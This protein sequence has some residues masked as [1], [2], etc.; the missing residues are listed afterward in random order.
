MGGCYA[1]QPMRARSLLATALGLL[2]LSFV[3]ATVPEAASQGRSAAPPDILLITID[4]LRADALGFAGNAKAAT[5]TLDRLARAGTWFPSAHAHNVIT[6]PSHANL[7]TG[8]Y[9]YQHGVRENSGFRLREGFPT[10]ATVLKAE[11][12]KTAAFVAAYPL[13]SQFGLD[14][15]FDVYDDR[16]PKGSRPTEFVLAERRGDEVVKA[17]KAWWDGAR[18]SRR[19]LW[20]HLFDPHA[21]YAPP[22]PFAQRFA[23]DPY[24]GE[25]AAVDSFLAPLLTPHLEGKEPP[26]LVVVTSDHGEALGEHGELT[27]GLFAYEPTLRVPLILW[28]AGVSAKR[29][30][31]PAR[32]VDL[33]PTVLAATGARAKEVEGQPRPGASLLGPAPTG[34]AADSYFEALSANLNRGWAP[35][36]GLIREGKKAIL[37]PLPEL[38]DLPKDPKELTNLFEGDKRTTGLILRNLPEESAWPPPRDAISA[39]EARRLQSLGYL[40]GSADAK[41]TYTAEDDPKTLVALDAKVHQVVDL[42]SRGDLGR[43]VVLAREIVQARPGM[44]LGHSL[45]S[46]VLLQLGDVPTAVEV[47]AAARKAGTTTESMLVQLGLSLAEIGR[48]AEAIE[49][50]RPLAEHD[51]PDAGNALAVALAEAGK[52]EEARQALA[53]VLKADPDNAKAYENLGLV[54]LRQSRWAEARE[55]SQKA[56]AINPQLPLAWNNLGVALYQERQFGPALD[57]WQ[58]AVELDPRLFDALFNLG[59]KAAEHGRPSVAKKALEAF[60]ATAPPRRYAPDIRRAQTLLARLPA[61]S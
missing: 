24:L 27:H 21:P 58:K 39:E 20:I 38:Y 51:N 60:V 45:L 54:A 41:A 43:A 61:G 25:V 49:V 37:L 31:R 8:L 12:Y 23:K 46:Q 36:R 34:P 33:F 44:A 28:G 9:P 22:A 3:G 18:G 29:D 6:L 26:A 13:D 40:S 15:G 52:G 7:L 55:Q 5:P 4:T 2:L 50:L 53:R 57:A 42:Y 47:M 19:F 17:A 10:L 32:H 35:L 56:L 14:R 30:E 48:A 11:G 16:L 59:V 1:L